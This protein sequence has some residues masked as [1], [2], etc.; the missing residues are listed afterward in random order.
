MLL[1]VVIT[2]QFIT[3]WVITSVGEVGVHPDSGM[4]FSVQNK[5]A[6]KPWKGMEE[7]WVHILTYRS[8]S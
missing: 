2:R 1:Q 6:I 7:T 5:W 4:L 8:Q 3:R